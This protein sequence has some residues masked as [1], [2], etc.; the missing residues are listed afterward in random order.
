MDDKY[1]TEMLGFSAFIRYAA[2]Q[3]WEI[4]KEVTGHNSCDFI[5]QTPD[6]LQR[7]E[8]KA[9]VSEQNVH[10]NSYFYIIGD[11]HLP[12]LDYLFVYT[13]KG[14]Y[15]IPAAELPAKCLALKQDPPEPG[16]RKRPTG[17]YERYRVD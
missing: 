15:W 4:W 13:P 7:V 6:G 16:S 11:F 10:D 14:S 9:S 3:D 2:N 5:A 8:V 17:K 12:Q 1:Q